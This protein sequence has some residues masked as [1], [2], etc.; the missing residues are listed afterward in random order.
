MKSQHFVK[1]ALATLS[2]FLFCSS[3]PAQVQDTSP[4]KLT[5]FTF[6]PMAVNTSTSPATITA[7]LQITDDLSGASWGYVEL[8][9][10]SGHQSSIC[11]F[12]LI[13]GTDLNGT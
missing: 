9:S 11:N 2:V 7:A 3:T 12:S 8:Y 4:P 10:P 5:G 6:S 1:I 13:S